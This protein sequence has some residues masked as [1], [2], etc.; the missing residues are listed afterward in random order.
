MGRNRNEPK[1]Q[2]NEEQPKEEK[3][4]DCGSIDSLTIDYQAITQRF[5]CSECGKIHS[6]TTEDKFGKVPLQPTLQPKS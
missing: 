3:C 6:V 2:Q 5:V 1:V 4:P